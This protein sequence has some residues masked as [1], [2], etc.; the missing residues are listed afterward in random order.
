MPIRLVF[1][2]RFRARKIF[3]IFK[4]NTFNLSKTPK[5]REYITAIVLGFMFVLR[6]GAGK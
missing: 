5:M 4:L 2:R 3:G 1:R 6:A